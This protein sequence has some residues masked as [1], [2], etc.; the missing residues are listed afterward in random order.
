[1]FTRMQTLNL[2]S[3]IIQIGVLIFVFGANP[4]LASPF[5]LDITDPEKLED[6]I[7]DR[8]QRI[9]AEP[10]NPV[11]YIERGDARF[12]AHEF[13]EAIE[14]YTTA[15]NIDDALSEAYFGR[16]VALARAGF[17]ED[18][19]EDLD[20]YIMRNPGSSIA[21]TKRGVRHLWLG[22]EDKAKTDFETALKLDPMNAEAHDDLGVIFAKHQQYYQAAD[23][24]MSAFEIDPTY[25]K[26]Y[27]NMAL[28]SYITDKDQLA[29][30][31]VDNSLALSPG[32]RNSMILKAKIL[33]AL[34][35]TAE[36]EVIMEEADFLPDA[37]WSER[38]PL[39]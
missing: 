24:F 4:V 26:A 8:N 37:N 35:R 7:N 3:H 28:I 39:N 38:V 30:M 10:E 29:L 18:G 11:P 36:A 31:F 33:E 21:Y 20:V 17:I 34:G 6:Y 23:H 32:S 1:M 16:G 12:L 22:D 9:K 14:D 5:D 15:L 25:Q 19:I 2:A 13:D 27:Y